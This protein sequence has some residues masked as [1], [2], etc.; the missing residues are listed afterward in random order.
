[1]TAV[2]KPISR[3]PRAHTLRVT[4]SLLA[5]ATAPAVAAPTSSKQSYLAL[6]P[7]AD[8]KVR[9]D[10]MLREWPDGFAKLDTTVKGSSSRTSALV[11]YDA[12]NVYFALH[13]DDSHIAR[14]ASAGKNE[15]HLTFELW[16]PNP[17]GGGKT[18]VVDVY[19]GDPGKLPAVIKVDGKVVSSAQAVEA[20]E[21]KGYSLEG[22][23]PWSALPAAGATRVGLRGRLEYTDASSPGQ[24]RRVVATSRAQGSAMPPVTLESDTGLIQALLEPKELG[25]TP[26]REAIGN[27]FGGPENE[28]VAVYGHFLSITGPG[29][30]DGKQFYFN[31]LDVANADSIRRL[32]LRDFDGDGR[33]EVVLQKRIG[34]GDRYREVLEVLQIGSDGAPLRVFIHEVAIKTEDGIAANEIKLSGSG[35]D[36]RI[37]IKQGKAEGFEPGSY[38]E[39]KIDG[40]DSALLPWQSVGTRVFEWRG[41]GLAL[42]EEK[43]WKAK[44]FASSKPSSGGSSA[45]PAAKAPP[46]PRPP[47]ADEMLDRVYALYKK[48]R[49]VGGTKP[50]YDFVTDV[51]EDDRPERVLVHGKDVVVFG[52]GFKEGLTYTFISVGVKD[53]KDILDVTS[54]DLTGDGRAEI[55]LRGVLQA[56]ASKELGGDVVQRE[57]LYVYSV[58]GDHLVRI[59]A[60][61]T[62]R[63]LGDKRIVGALSFTPGARGVAIELRPGRAIGWNEQNY[64]FPEDNA[65][66]GG[67]EPLLLPWG[68]QKARAYAFTGSAYERR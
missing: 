54:R 31:E 13:T 38:R 35:K 44:Q 49:G 52:K 48:D 20:P 34:G 53:P 18:H 32:E 63:A 68:S 12:S 15:D 61:E 60:A 14:T 46:P 9:V 27:V 39:P 37:E 23:M 10:G 56:Q 47:S 62:G 7:M 57:A 64:P 42:A 51:A 25:L 1:M 16:F 28:R 41:Q 36:A 50:K 6:E 45:A 67:L 11:G 22:R 24:V 43:P 33:Q 66:A 58:V 26:A 8:K 29:Y 17:G 3:K 2:S 4:A 59:F 19:P 40:I 65:P 30:K 5:L 21:D 55:I